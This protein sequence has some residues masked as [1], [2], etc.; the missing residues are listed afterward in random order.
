MC[1]VT[2]AQSLILL[3]VPHEYQIIISFKR[4]AFLES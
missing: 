3:D 4:T 2:K 1:W